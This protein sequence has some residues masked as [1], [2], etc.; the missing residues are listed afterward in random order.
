MTDQLA[1]RSADTAG[2]AGPHGLGARFWRLCTAVTVSSWGDG[3]EVAALPLLAAS[4]STDPRQVSGVTAAATLPWLVFGLVAGGVVDRLDRRKLMWRVNLA[5]TGLVGLLAVLV[6]LHRMY[7][8]LLYLLVFVLGIGQTLFDTASQAILP[9]LVDQDQLDTANGRRQ[10]GET[11]GASLV[12]PPAGGALYAVAAVIPFGLDALTFLVAGGLVRGIRGD[13]AAHVAAP[14][15]PKRSLRADIGEGLRWLLRHPVLRPLAAVLGLANLAMYMGEG[16]L[17][18]FALRDL[19]IGKADYGL[20]LTAMA[21]GGLLGGLVAGRLA[22][23]LG[24]VRCVLVVLLGLLLSQV[25]IGV[26]SNAFLVGAAGTLGTF[27]GT[28][29]NVVTISLRQRLIPRQLLGRVNSAYR[30]IGMGSMPIGA[31]LGGAVAAAWGL[32]APFL[33]A[34]VLLAL[35]LVLAA[36]RITTAKITASLAA[37]EEPT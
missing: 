26:S 18:L 10:V 34:G 19:G 6:A 30:M 9:D 37:I 29:W 12:G 16:I 1:D 11:A 22:A 24:P 5:R 4:L 31:L 20:L 13:F 25:L 33:L 7:L 3:L 23:A 2:T 35:A 8:P 14:S 17:V 15:S 27:A 28:L 21:I 32:R 36:T